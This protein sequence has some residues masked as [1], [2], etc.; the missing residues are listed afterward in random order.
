MGESEELGVTWVQ[1]PRDKAGR[2]A[3]GM[4]GPES[5]YR[6]EGSKGVAIHMRSPDI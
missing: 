6:T 2:R 1:R 4:E 5:M 3:A